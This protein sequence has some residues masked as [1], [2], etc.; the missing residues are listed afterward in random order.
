MKNCVA[1]LFFVFPVR[2]KDDEPIKILNLCTKWEPSDVCGEF[3]DKRF[4]SEGIISDLSKQT[5]GPMICKIIE[6]TRA[7][8][9]CG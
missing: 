7:P 5:R 8:K 3:N 6:R 1:N 2:L 9:G 4:L